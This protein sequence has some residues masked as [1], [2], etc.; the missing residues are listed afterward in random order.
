[1]ARATSTRKAW[2]IKT[3]REEKGLTQDQVAAS[4]GFA[5]RQTVADIEAGKRRIQPE[6]LIRLTEIFGVDLEHLTDP[7]RLVGEG[8]FN[9]RTGDVSADVIDEFEAQAGRWIATYRELRG[10]AGLRS[11]RLTHKLDLSERST[12]EDAQEAGEQVHALWNLGDVP[13]VRLPD[14]I[15][16]ELDTEVLFVDAPPGLSGAAIELPGLNA[17]LINRSEPAGRRNFDLAHELFHLLTWEAMPPTRVEAREIPR[18]KGNRVER[19]AE[20]FAGALLM[21]GQV[22]RDRWKDRGDEELTDWLNRTAT[23]LQVTAL[24]LK[25][26]L[27][28]ADLLAKPEAQRIDDRGL[29]ANGGGAQAPPPPRFSPDFVARIHDAVEGGRLSLAKATR[30]LGV[31]PS[32]FAELCDTY[33]HD[34]SY[35]L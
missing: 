16:E 3:L 20:N 34:L 19:L 26:R 29:A 10:E 17:I 22:L 12:F 31:T 7:F 25:W 9:F 4:M 5:S 23:D 18:R 15:R 33:G 1:M 27:V 11:S 32:A 8:R 6:E 35:E 2:R 14:A 21:P 30:L 28:A 13:A 24:A